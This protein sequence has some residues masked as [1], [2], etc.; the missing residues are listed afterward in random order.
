[1][2]GA[3][4]MLARYPPF[5]KAQR[6]KAARSYVQECIHGVGPSGEVQEIPNQKRYEGERDRMVEWATKDAGSSHYY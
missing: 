2:L 4:V 3:L 5:D 6:D 1:M